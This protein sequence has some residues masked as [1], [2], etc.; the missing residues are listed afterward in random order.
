MDD[1]S[2]IHNLL[3]DLEG[4]SGG[5]D[6]NLFI[7]QEAHLKLELALVDSQLETQQQIANKSENQLAALDQAKERLAE[8]RQLAALEMPPMID[9]TGN[10]DDNGGG[11]NTTENLEQIRIKVELEKARRVALNSYY[12][13][14][15]Q[16]VLVNMYGG[17]GS[18]DMDDNEDEKD[19]PLYPLES[20]T[21]KTE[22]QALLQLE[23]KQR[24][25]LENKIAALEAEK[26][27]FEDLDKVKEV[28]NH[29]ENEIKTFYI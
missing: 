9:L 28:H 21:D 20:I 10:D 14:L 27:W 23:S 29:M 1:L 15:K 16:D 13:Q 7:E 2:V 11:G 25:L 18:D 6:N 4:N 5:R 26:S 17:G 12:I 3:F 19:V 24:V 8:L 22:L